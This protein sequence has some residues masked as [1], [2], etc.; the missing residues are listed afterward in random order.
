MVLRTRE[1]ALRA[2]SEVLSFDRRTQIVQL[3]VR[4]AQC[5]TP[6][7]RT[8]LFRAQEG[9][10]QGKL[11]VKLK[12]R[13]T[14][15]T[16]E[17]QPDDTQTLAAKG[18]IDDARISEELSTAIEALK[19]AV[20]LLD[21][22]PALSQRFTRWEIARAAL[23]YADDVTKLIS[24][25]TDPKKNAAVQEQVATMVTRF[26]PWWYSQVSPIAQACEMVL[27]RAPHTK[28]RLGPRTLLDIVATTELR[29]MY[30][31][32][33]TIPNQQAMIEPL[34]KIHQ[35]LQRILA[36]SYPQ[37]LPAESG[38]TV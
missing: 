14:A 4:L 16:P 7:A 1:D 30:A 18:P 9:L 37:G 25:G 3:T 6:E 20:V 23:F 29:A 19:V 13:K 12:E 32:K 26:R 36:Q 34:T 17:A 33:D 11:Q 24:E 2:L 28:W 5:L 38:F 22:F 15:P 21:V 8:I 10:V 31:V 27:Q 35:A